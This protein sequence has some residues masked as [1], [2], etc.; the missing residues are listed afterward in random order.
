M[1][2]IE[3]RETALMAAVSAGKGSP[4]PANALGVFYARYDLTVKAEAEFQDALRTGEYVSALVNLGNLRFRDGKFADALA[5]YQRAF[6]Q[7]PHEPLVLLGCARCNQQLKNYGMA[8]TEYEE[9][10]KIMPEMANQYAYLQVQ[11]DES[12]RKAE[13]GGL[14]SAVEWMEEK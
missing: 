6:A 11:S 9:L 1:R 12:T 3:P 2:E 5:F 8:K 10:R 7:A 4:K 13:E 14:L